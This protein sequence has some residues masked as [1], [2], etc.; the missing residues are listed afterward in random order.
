MGEFKFRYRNKIM[1]IVLS[2]TI[3]LLSNLF[4]NVSS[5]ITC[6]DD[7][8]WMYIA[9]S[10]YKVSFDPMTWFETQEGNLSGQIPMNPWFMKILVMENRMMTREMK[11]VFISTMIIGMMMFVL[12]WLACCH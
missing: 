4:T 10:C 7:P 11:I 8:G 2:F 6:P 3:I 5:M 12:I 1:F 9:N